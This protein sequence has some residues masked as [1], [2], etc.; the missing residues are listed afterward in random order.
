MNNNPI[1]EKLKELQETDI[2][3]NALN[4][5]CDDKSAT[6]NQIKENIQKLQKKMEE[7]KQRAKQLKIEIDKKDLELKSNEEK[8]KKLNIHLN[9]VKTNKEY[10]VLSNEIK[11]I[12]ADSD[13]IE[14]VI[15][16]YFGQSETIQ[17]EIKDLE[18][19]ITGENNKF[20]LLSVEVDKEICHIKKEIENFC[21]I[22]Q[23]NMGRIDSETLSKY[24]KIISNK[25]DKTALAKVN[26]TDYSFTCQGCH[27]DVT[28]QQ[29]NE[30]MKGKELVCC[31]TCL[32]ILYVD[33]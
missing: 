32:R 24:E 19:A 11:S 18:T 5:L 16:N 23:E 20:N 29:V 3:I 22:R 2:K 26:I 13:I 6:L 28:P 21:Q 33:K 4:K 27:M 9:T 7:I 30:I 15:L 17:K 10:S 25:V 31:K 1:I 14:D 8:T 12:K